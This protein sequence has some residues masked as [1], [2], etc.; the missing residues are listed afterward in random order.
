[1]TGIWTLWHL[2]ALVLLIF[3]VLAYLAAR[4]TPSLAPYA[5]DVAAILLVIVTLLVIGLLH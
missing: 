2:V 4:R 1:M 5:G 3:Y